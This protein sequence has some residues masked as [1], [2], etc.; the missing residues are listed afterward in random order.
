[1]RP[2]VVGLLFGVMWFGLGPEVAPARAQ[3]AAT[4][5]GPV[6]HPAVPSIESAQRLFYIGEYEEAAAA[7]LQLR[8]AAP[9]D[10]S[11]YELRTSA[12]HFLIKRQLGDAKDRAAALKA[13]TACPALLATMKQDVT[14][15]QELARARLKVQPRDV[16]ALFFLGK[17]DLNHVW[18]YLGT[19]GQR[20]GWG[21]YWE[22]RR[23]LDSAL[24]IEPAHVRAGVARAWIDYIVDTRVPRGLRW[25]LGGGNKKGA[26][27]TMRSAAVANTDFYS[28]TEAGFGLW[29]MLGREAQDAEAVTVAERL[30]VDFPENKEIT[31][32]LKARGH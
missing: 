10:L 11:T 24:A 30:A 20:T 1:M 18:L 6:V 29:E 22:A 32:F 16:T 15:G 7:A 2:V 3:L 21:E 14:R 13:C 28:R 19:L 25:V 4:A 12:L 17:I 23:S 31:R 27:K 26:L 8:E 9:D 5:G